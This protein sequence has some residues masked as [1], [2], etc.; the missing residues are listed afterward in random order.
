MA[1]ETIERL[2]ERVSGEVIAPDDAGYEEAR[3]VYNAM[4]DRRPNVVVRCTV[5]RRRGRRRRLRAR[6][7]ARR[8]PFAAAVTACPA[9][10]PATM[11]LSSTCQE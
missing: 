8:W 4:I 7:R 11:R 1:T 10:A 9:S 2:S 6:E 5:D 3:K